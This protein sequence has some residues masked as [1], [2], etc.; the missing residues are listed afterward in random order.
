MKVYTCNMLNKRHRHFS[1]PYL[2]Y[3]GMNSRR[4]YDTCCNTTTKKIKQKCNDIILHDV[5]T[6]LYILQQD[7]NAMPHIKTTLS[8]MP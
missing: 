6:T 8:H 4:I 5:K 2:C 1:S 3:G 7:G